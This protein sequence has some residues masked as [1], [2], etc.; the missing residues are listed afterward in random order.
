M[1]NKKII[2]SII[3]FLV[4]I[5]I[6][7]LFF[8]KECSK[9][10]MTIGVISDQTGVVAE[11]GKWVQNGI[12]IALETIRETDPSFKLH[13]ED[14][15]SDVKVAL[16]AFERMLSIDKTR[17]I[18]CG[19][20]SSSVMAL[21]SRANSTRTLLFSTIASSPN[22][23]QTGDF[24]F[25]NRVLGTMEVES[26]VKKLNQL[27]INTIAIVA[28]NN[29]AGMPYIDAFNN[30]N[31]GG[32]VTVVS[33]ILVEPNSND[34]RTELI[35]LK[36]LHPD[37]VFLVTPVNQ[38]LNFIKQAKNIDF[39]TKWLGISTLKTDV[40]TLNGGSL[41]EKMIIASESVDEN[42]SMFS[43]FQRK[44][45]KRFNETPTIYS[46]NG[47]DATMILYTLMKKYGNDVMAIQQAL[48]SEQF[49][50]LT[51]TISFDTN[52]IIQ[53]KRVDLFEIKDGLFV[54]MK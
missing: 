39:S 48:Y 2:I 25:S 11:Y 5:I 42:S 30:A 49:E 27:D 53:N 14:G 46:V 6:A 29:E 16:V 9:A 33:E 38:T 21:S 20:N 18:I 22:M 41:V 26:L 12:T 7:F 47:Y 52:G 17:L 43:D 8:H 50:T 34:F 51:G 13:I 54:K 28:H 10:E 1:K 36:A 40:L 23:T 32:T 24:V 19:S 35:K 3:I 31:K 4:V 45:Q 44:Y 15:R 37:A